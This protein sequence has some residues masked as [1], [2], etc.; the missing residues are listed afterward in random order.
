MSGGPIAI[1]YVFPHN[2]EVE[3]L[4]SPTASSE[5]LYQFPARLEEGDRTGIYLRI[6]PQSGQTW[7]GFFAQGFDSSQVASGI[8]SC[9][10]PGWVCVASGGYAYLVEAGNPQSW[11]QIEQRPVVEVK[12]VSDLQLLLFV[13]FTSITGLGTSGG[14]WTT[15]RLSWEGL[16]IT[17]IHAGILLGTGWDMIADKEVPFEVDLLTGK[18][19]GGA[20]PRPSM[21]Q[22]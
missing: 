4:D 14:L 7:I 21:D 13:G 5:R 1:H 11:M 8:C 6:T 17:E 18:S 2:Y 9:P 12:P 16:S 20:W 10:D 3:L 19:K 15:D 22:S